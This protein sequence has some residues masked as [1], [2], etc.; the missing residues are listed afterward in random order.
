MSLLTTFEVL[1]LFKP[2]A[3]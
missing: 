2:T 1:V 3:G